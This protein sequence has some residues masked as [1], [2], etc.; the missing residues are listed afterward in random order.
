[1]KYRV[2]RDLDGTLSMPCHTAKT[3]KAHDDLSGMSN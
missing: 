3:Q 2:A 1:M